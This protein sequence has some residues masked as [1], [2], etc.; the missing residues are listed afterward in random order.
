MHALKEKNRAEAELLVFGEF[1]LDSIRYGKTDRTA[2]LNNIAT[3]RCQLGQ[4]F[5]V[6]ATLAKK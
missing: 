4:L 5:F 6:T 1:L 2:P 3:A